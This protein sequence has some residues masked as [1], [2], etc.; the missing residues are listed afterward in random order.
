MLLLKVLALLVLN[1]KPSKC[2]FFNVCQL[3]SH[4][5]LKVTRAQCEGTL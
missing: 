2:C 1:M 5:N 4:C 3:S